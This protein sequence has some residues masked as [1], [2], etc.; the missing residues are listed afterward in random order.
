MRVTGRATSA[1]ITEED[2]GSFDLSAN[3][4]F[5]CV[6]AGSVE[7]TFTNIVVGQSGNIKLVVGSGHAITANA[8]VGINSTALNA[9]Q[10][11]GTYNLSYYVPGGNAD[12]STSGTS[13]VLVSVS[14]ALT[15][16]GA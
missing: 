1:S 8:V 13:D 6:T 12:G 2:D 3:N 16:Q 4:N 9:L 11:A 14:G 10:T 5:I 15:S 7:L